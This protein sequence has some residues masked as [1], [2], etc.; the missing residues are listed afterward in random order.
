MPESWV[1]PP[2]QAELLPF[3][4]VHS[5]RPH[6]EVLGGPTWRHQCLRCTAEAAWRSLH[7]PLVLTCGLEKGHSGKKEMLTFKS[8]EKLQI[9]CIWYYIPVLW[10]IIVGIGFILLEKKGSWLKMDY[11]GLGLD[12]G[13]I[14]KQNF[15]YSDVTI[16]SCTVQRSELILVR[17]SIY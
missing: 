9:Y 7:G 1:W 4:G 13:P 8:L 14:V 6:V 3:G 5:V 15:Y 17:D 10:K 12:G 16:S 11:L 2:C